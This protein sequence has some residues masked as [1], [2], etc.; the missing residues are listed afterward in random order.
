MKKRGVLYYYDH[1]EEILLVTMFVV[2]V[3]VIFLQVFM[4]YVVNNSLSWTEEMGRYLFIWLS[5]LGISAG[6][7]RG[8]HIKITVLVDKFPFKAAQIIN[9]ISC[10]ITIVVVLITGYYSIIL[11]NMLLGIHAQWFSLD[12]SILPVYASM[13]ISCGLMTIRSIISI[14]SSVQNYLNY[15]PS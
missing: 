2:M 14:K 9:V 5:W 1:L 13:P 11:M 3:A 12:I 8:E 7:K 15:D 10:I 6:E 4:R